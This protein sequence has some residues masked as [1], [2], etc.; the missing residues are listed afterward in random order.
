MDQAP[1]GKRGR[2]GVFSDKFR[3][4]AY[5]NDKQLQEQARELDKKVKSELKN[6]GGRPLKEI[7]KETFEGLCAIDCTIREFECVLD[8]DSNTLSAW[9][10]RT[11]GMGFS[12]IFSLKR[13]FGNVSLRRAQMRLACENL[14]P[15]MLI[16]LGKNRLNQ[17]DKI[18]MS[19]DRTKLDD[20]KEAE[21]LNRISGL[22]KAIKA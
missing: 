1:K 22:L 11:Y 21:T 9:C 2:K 5:A 19:D 16:F 14:N 20:Q 10:Y 17:T 8:V 13:Q 15:A 7:S 6:L 3:K 18:L 12:E 4:P